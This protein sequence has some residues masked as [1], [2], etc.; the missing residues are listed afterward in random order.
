MTE[1]TA[2]HNLKK[3]I[4]LWRTDREPNADTMV[5]EIDRE[6]IDTLYESIDSLEKLKADKER[7]CNKCVH[8]ISDDCSA[9]KC[10]MQTLD[11]YKDKIIKDFVIKLI[12]RLL[13]AIHPQDVESMTNLINE[14]AEQVKAEKE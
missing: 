1:N 4:E 14:I 9:W 7:D 11:E 13:D 3:V 12:T 8:Y 6:F 10:D 5:I 2:I